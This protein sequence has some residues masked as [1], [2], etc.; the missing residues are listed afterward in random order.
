MVVMMIVFNRCSHK[1][2][3]TVLQL[4]RGDNQYKSGVC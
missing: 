1:K 4:L 2:H 3:H